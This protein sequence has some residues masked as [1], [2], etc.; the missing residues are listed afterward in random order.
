M[1]LEIIGTYLMTQHS[2]PTML[3]GVSSTSPLDPSTYV[4]PRRASI[5]P[6]RA[7]VLPHLASS[8]LPPP[9]CLASSFLLLLP[10]FVS[11]FLLLPPRL[12]SS[13]PPSLPHPPLHQ[14]SSPLLFPFR[15]R[16]RRWH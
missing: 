14:A 12:A 1:V 7:S 11:S 2:Q 8:S 6:R 5:L 15:H 13:S 10:R 16:S 9:P 4:L 3:L